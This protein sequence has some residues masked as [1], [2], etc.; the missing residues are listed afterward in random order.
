MPQIKLGFDVI[1]IPT[2]TT[3]VPL[4]DIV[5][6]VPLRD[7]VGNILVTEENGPVEAL[8]KADNSL[9]VAVNNEAPDSVLSIE[10]QFAE[11]S[12]VSSTLL[13]IP[14]AETQLSL[15]SDVSTYGLNAEEWE[16]YRYNGVFGRPAG[17]YNRFNPTHGNHYSTR[18]VENINEQALTI[19]SFPV[20][21]TFP[22]GPNYPN[23]NKNTWDRYLSF[24]QLGNDLYQEYAGQY[25]KFAAE[26][27]LDPL[28]VSPDGDGD[29][30]YPEDEQQGYDAIEPWTIAWMNMRDSLLLHPV[31][32]K[33]IPFPVGYDATSTRPGAS[34]GARYFGLLQ[35]KK[36]YRY[37]PG[38]IS[39]FTYGFRASRDEASLANIIEWGIGNPTDEYVY[40]IKGPQFNIVRRSTVRL[41][42]DVLE[43]MGFQESDQKV[44]SSREPFNEDQF[45]ELVIP[46]EFFNG[47]PLNGNGRSGY[48]LDPTKVTMYKIEF[49]WYGAIGAKFY[50]YVPVDNNEC[51]WILIHTLNIENQLGEP[52]LQD[53]YFKFRYLQDIQ[54]T[55]TV[56]TPQYLYKYGASCYVDGGDNSAGKYYTYTSD[57][58]VVNSARNNSMIGIYPKQFIKNQDGYEKP[59]K[60]NVY[61]VDLK[62]DCDQLTQIEV[63][64]ISGCPNF[65]HHYSPSLHAK[66]NGQIRSINIDSAGQNF[67]INPQDP[68]IIS[69]IT[70]SSQ[71]AVLTTETA[72][73]YYN[74]QKVSIETI[75]GEDI[76]MTE[77]EFQSYYVY[78]FSDTQIGL[79]TD[80]NL[81][82][83]LDSSNF[84]TYN[85]SKANAVGNPILRLQDDDSKIINQGIWSTYVNRQGEDGGNFQRIGTEDL[86]QKQIDN[87][88]VEV[89]TG[90]LTELSAIDKTAARFTSYYDAIAAATYP[91][92]GNAFDVN[93][94]NPVVRE[95]TGQFC[96]FIIGVTEK[97]PTIVTEQDPL[98]NPIETL[99]FQRKDGVTN[100]DPDLEDVLYAEFT[101]S[102]IF[103]NRDGYETT[104]GD[105]PSGIKMDIDYRLSRPRGADSGICSGVRITIQERLEYGVAYDN[106]NPLIQTETGHYIIWDEE[107]TTLLG[108]FNLVGGEFGI[109]DQSSGLTFIGEIQEFVANQQTGAIKYFAPIS[110]DPQNATFTLKLSPIKIEDR[111]VTGDTIK[112]IFKTKIFSFQ[113]KP[114]YCTIWMRDNARVN[115]I[116]IT[117]YINGTTRAFSPEWLTNDGID[118]VFSGSSSTNV[119]AANYLEKE[120]LASTSADVQNVQP[121]RPGTLKD[122]IYVS[123]DK[124]NRFALDRVYGP[125]RT[126]IAPGVLNT[127]ATFVTAKSL[128]NNDE[129]IVSISITTKEA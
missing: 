94:L 82:S 76:G 35:S 102:G 120:R 72:H 11:T 51:R 108:N 127:Q 60:K 111:L 25:P 55:S 118:V 39:G 65:G 114:L 116:T 101:H 32:G 49:G 48:L 122:T 71:G 92:T 47:D 4:Y 37:Q 106:T 96:E 9:S 14:R 38:R 125:D 30:N 12:E 31:T 104:E 66:Q 59:N 41:P 128:E 103:R 80:A 57:D 89:Y 121:L 42:N 13:G 75:I 23:Y 17:W 112:K 62:I 109:G 83:V 53:P 15:F 7:G 69:S 86:Y 54:D 64:E 3:L 99:K 107:P 29:V 84:G 113:P 70:N 91:I 98:G 95:S 119:P 8:S 10:E 58:K 79:Y 18:L 117:E 20:P 5:Q 36:A 19:E 67:T 27:F 44:V 100:D 22:N 73:G 2:V 6:G 50:A 74:G 1:P 61:P 129:N 24:I 52:C 43:R 68:I 87:L 97:K 85:A 28:V 77:V 110:G 88:P 63:V 124:S 40:Q 93:Y 56:R 126:T 78:V 26:N 105:S 81:T 16:F 123:P 45:Y 90:V 115:N 33:P 21:Y 46:R 34:S